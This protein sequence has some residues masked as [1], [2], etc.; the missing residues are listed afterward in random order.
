VERIL[1]TL[2]LAAAAVALATFAADD[3]TAAAT[4]IRWS[5]SGTFDHAATVAPGKSVEICGQIEPRLPVDWRFSATGP[6]DFNIHRHS[7]AELTYA[8]R[9]YLTREQ[10]GTFS[11]TFSFDWCWMWTNEA[12]EPASLRVELKR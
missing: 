2:I 11:P 12:T 10:H 7:G 6:L 3:A 5:S 9:S 4:D 8:M 1:K